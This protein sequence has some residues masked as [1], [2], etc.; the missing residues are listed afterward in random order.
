[1]NE[2]EKPQ[3]AGKLYYVEEMVLCLKT[4]LQ[5]CRKDSSLQSTDELMTKFNGRSSIK[6]CLPVK[7]VKQGIKVWMRCDSL[8][9][10]TY[11]MNIY[12]GKEPNPGKGTLGEIVVKR[13]ASTVQEKDVTLAFERFF[14]SVYLINTLNFTSVH[15]LEK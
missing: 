10:Y 7:P 6:Q 15:L 9:V 4:T 2:P 5:R 1:L 11:D 13:L 12:A 3:S 8:T 14:T